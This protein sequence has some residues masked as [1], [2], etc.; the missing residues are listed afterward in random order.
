MENSL[1]VNIDKYNLGRTYFRSGKRCLFDFIREILI[2]ETPE[3]IIRQKFVRYLIEELK[4]PKSKIEIEVPM[5]HFKKGA[6]GRADIVVYGEDKEGYNIPI[7]IIECKAPNVP[8][9]D[10]VWFQAYRYDHILGANFIIITNGNYTYGAVLDEE[11]EEYCLIEEIPKYQQFLSRGEFKLIHNDLEGWERPNF[12]EITSKKTVEEFF[13]LGWL[14]EDT[15]EKLYPLIM[16]L[17]GFIQDT[18]TNL[19][20]FK[21]GGINIIEDGDRYTSF[22]NAAGG[23]WEGD[24]RYFILEDAEGNNQI[25]S[26]SIFG[27]LKCTNHP[28]FGNRKGNT[29]LV[30]AIDDFDKRHNSLQLNIDKYTKIQGNEYTIWHDGKLTVGKSGS[31]KRKEV[32]EYIRSKEPTMVLPS[33]NIILGTFDCGKEI[34]WSQDNTKQFIKNLIKYAILRDEFRKM[35]QEISN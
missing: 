4:V 32:I 19:S 5:T 7:I 11:N 20:P 25:V 27:S 2:V 18:D 13:Q 1:R 29:S 12:S 28:K 10:E 30:V 33:G 15:D 35:K 8:L 24:Y 3:E 14:G 26:I 22:G 31:A 6:R 34:K 9:I 17:A 21:V 23:S 16:N